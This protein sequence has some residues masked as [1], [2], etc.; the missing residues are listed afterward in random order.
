VDI[1]D[2]GTDPDDTVNDTV[3]PQFVSPQI[4]ISRKENHIV[5]TKVTASDETSS[6]SYSIG[7]GEDASLFS[8]YGTSG[9]LVFKSNP[10]YED[11]QDSNGDNLYQV[12]VKAIDSA[13]NSSYQDI[14]ITVL[15][16]VEESNTGDSDGDYIP[17]NIEYLLDMNVTNEDEDDNQKEDGLQSTGSFGDSFF[18]MQWHLWD[19]D[20]RMTNDSGVPTEGIE[21]ISDLNL[22]DLYHTYMGY[23][24]GTP[25]IVQVVDTGVEAEHEDLIENMD[26]SRSY[27]GGDVGNPT[28]KYPHGTMVAGIMAGRALNGKGVRG[29]IPFA[30]IAGSD[31]LAEQTLE[32]LTKVWLTGEGANEI[33]VSNNSWGSYFDTDT[34]Y[35]SIMKLGVAK[36]R[37]G[38]GRIYVFA[39]GNDR[40]D[41]GDAN[42]QYL[43]SNR[44]AIT[45][46]GAKNDNTYADYSTPGA[47]ILVS[48]YSGNYVED[49][50]TIGTTTIMGSGGSTTWDA[51]SAKNYTYAMNGTS[52]A[53]P[54]VSSAIA[55]TL[56]A[57]PDLTWR[58]VKYLLATTARKVDTSDTAWITN[59]A[60]WSYNI[61]Y[62][63]GLVSAQ[64][65]I[66]QCVQGYK[67]LP[68]EEN[69]VV[70]ETF[71]QLIPDDNST[72]EFTLDM[73]N[74]IAVEWVEVII[75][76][77]STYASD[78]HIELVSPKNTSVTLMTENT[79][80]G[81]EYITSS[82]WMDGGFRF[83]TAA[84]LDESS[85]GTWTVKIRDALS[86]DTGSVKN[87]QIQIYGH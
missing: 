27:S 72:Q 34:D 19:Y 60:G 30:K 59:D 26:L 58:D 12:T 66:D 43:L 69:Y 18:D 10:D 49:S 53:A 28:G 32:T 82:S 85:A 75:D 16:I 37:D 78:Y 23:N 52:S 83:G 5:L 47:N 46:A 77:N 31:W 81:R 22:L 51:D 44:F 6:V 21:G 2:E 67:S 8:I 1:P 76:N 24:S 79:K 45:V 4:A 36:L 38:K 50:P 14:N 74:D 33:A 29:I 11:P 80:N 40:E 57:C 65:M 3:P 17:D 41:Q 63:F 7:G 25:M 42:L 73:G 20:S 68:D 35:E 70:S 64:D 71:D 15:N 62:G 13:G 39:A 87:I 86:G 54:M 9:T 61:N 48:G 84:M 56:E 55:L